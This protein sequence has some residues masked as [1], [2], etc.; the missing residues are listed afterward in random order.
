MPPGEAGLAVHRS[1]PVS[2][3]DIDDALAKMFD[4]RATTVSALKAALACGH[5]IAETG[6]RSC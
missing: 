3:P 5:Q 6:R 1:M 4:A 2:G